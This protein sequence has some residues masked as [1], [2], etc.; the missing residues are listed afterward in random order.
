MRRNLSLQTLSPRA[1][2]EMSYLEKV[3]EELEVSK[4]LP[5]LPKLTMRSGWKVYKS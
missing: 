2:Q 1:V 4:K 3:E 5:K